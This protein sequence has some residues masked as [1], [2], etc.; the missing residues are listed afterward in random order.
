MK[1]ISMWIGVS[2]GALL[3]IAFVA[4]SVMAGGP[5]DALYMVRY[6]LPHMHRGNLK[7]GDSAPDAKLFALNGAETFH[8]RQRTGGK[9][10]V[11]VFGSFT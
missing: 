10:L 7:V 2:L 5:K 3:L 11:L 6:A 9:P 8:V 1:K 4:L